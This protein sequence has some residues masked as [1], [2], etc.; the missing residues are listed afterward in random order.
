ML[1]AIYA[2]A[3]NAYNLQLY[4]SI[5]KS[6]NCL[7]V[8]LTVDTRTHVHITFINTKFKENIFF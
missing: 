7:I 2:H 4:C 5:L 3:A 8:M 6:Y 1:Q